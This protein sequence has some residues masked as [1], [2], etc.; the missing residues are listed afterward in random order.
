MSDFEISEHGHVKNAKRFGLFKCM[1][2]N[3]C[4]LI[5]IETISE[6]KP[7]YGWQDEK[8]DSICCEWYLVFLQGTNWMLIKSV[9]KNLFGK[10]SVQRKIK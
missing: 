6:K 8:K 1:I 5:V 4:F 10:Y 9:A 7:E 3:I 2:W